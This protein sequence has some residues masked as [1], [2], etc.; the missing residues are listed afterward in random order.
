MPSWSSECCA[1]TF[2]RHHCHSYVFAAQ[3]HTYVVLK[4]VHAKHTYNASK[5]GTVHD[6]QVRTQSVTESWRLQA[7]QL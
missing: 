7:L 6:K 5:T 3:C 1:R 2:A 4:G